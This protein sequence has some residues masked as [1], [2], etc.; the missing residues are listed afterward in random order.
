MFPELSVMENIY[1]GHHLKRKGSLDWRTMRQK[2]K[3]LLEKMELDINPETA[4]KNLSVAQRHMVEIA[5]AR[6]IVYFQ[7]RGTY[8]QFLLGK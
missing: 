1:M 3:E 6:E 2:T 4:V 8:I 5:M 7:N